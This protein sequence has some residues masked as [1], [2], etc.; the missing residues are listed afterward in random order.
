[1]EKRSKFGNYHAIA[2]DDAL[3]LHLARSALNKCGET[4]DTPKEEC[5]VILSLNFFSPK[6]LWSCG[7]VVFLAGGG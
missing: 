4:S 5:T 6:N 2:Y 3:V 1:M 7:H